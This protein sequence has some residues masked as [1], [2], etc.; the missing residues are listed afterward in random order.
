MF[1]IDSIPAVFAVTTDPFIVFTSNAF[2]IL[3]LRSLYFL[4]AGM[5][6]RFTYLKVGLAALLVF[7]GVKILISGVYKMPVVVSLAAIT[8][9]L[10][11]AIIASIW[12]ARRSAAEPDPDDDDRPG[13]PAP[14]EA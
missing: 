2:A 10:G 13:R 14:Q 5:I 6:T 7:A 8:A 9:I 3:G 11:V 1:A 12:S 4:L